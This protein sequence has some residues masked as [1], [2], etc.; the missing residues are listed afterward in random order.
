MSVHE[1]TNDSTQ[2]TDYTYVKISGFY[3]LLVTDISLYT[4]IILYING[5]ITAS[6]EVVIKSYTPNT[7]YLKC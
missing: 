2:Q 4:N 5:K 3:T 6:Y 7:I 1:K